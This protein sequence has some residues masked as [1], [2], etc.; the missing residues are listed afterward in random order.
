M[1]INESP[2]IAQACISNSRR[3]QL[4]CRHYSLLC[5]LVASLFPAILASAAESGPSPKFK[6]TV[7]DEIVVLKEKYAGFKSDRDHQRQCK[8]IVVKLLDG[9]ETEAD[10]RYLAHELSDVLCTGDQ[11]R[12]HDYY[13]LWKGGRLLR[14][15]IN[16]DKRVLECLSR[17]ISKRE[18]SGASQE[19]LVELSGFAIEFLTDFVEYDGNVSVKA[20][21]INWEEW[22]RFKKWLD[23]NHD[24]LE[25]DKQTKK[26]RVPARHSN[27]VQ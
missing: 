20:G 25:F 14:Q 12:L 1:T 4:K 11:F 16:D 6:Q 17:K 21:Y 24:R 27:G 3:Q 10:A 19:I 23:D 18:A 5:C 2:F 15:H 8:K 7:A 22:D 26:F 9:V 13:V